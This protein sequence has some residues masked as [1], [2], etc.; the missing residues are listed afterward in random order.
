MSNVVIPPP[1]PWTLDYFQKTRQEQYAYTA[2]VIY[3]KNVDAKFK[4]VR[5]PVKSGKRS[6]PEI[7]SLINPSCEHIFVSS[8]NRKADKPQHDELKKYGI[9]VQ[10]TYNKKTAEACVALVMQFVYEGKEVHVH[11]DELDYGCKHDQILSGVYFKLKE[12]EKVSFILY[13]ATIDVVKSNYLDGEISGFHVLEPFEPAAQMYYGVDKYIEDNKLVQST[14]FV[15]FPGGNGKMVLTEQG[16]ECIQKLLEDTYNPQK[17]QHIGVLRLSGKK[18]GVHDFRLFKNHVHVVEEFAREYIRTNFGEASVVRQGIKVVF[19]NVKWDDEDY[20]SSSFDLDVPVLIVICQVAGRSTEWKCHPFLSW[21][22]TCRSRSTT[23]STLIQDQERVVFYKTDRNE[24]TDITLY[25]NKCCALYSANKINA[26]EMIMLTRKK[27]AL[28]LNGKCE[29]ASKVV[30]KAPEIFEKWEDVPEKVILKLK[31]K[32]EDFIHDG[33]KLQK[34]M[35]Y[36]KQKDN[37]NLHYTVKVPYWEEKKFGDDE[38]MYMTNIRGS[39]GNF[40]EWCYLENKG[41]KVTST[42]LRKPVWRKSDLMKTLSLGMS[43]TNPV[44]LNV[45]YEDGETNADNYKFMVREIERLEPAV[46]RNDSMYNVSE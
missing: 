36:T 46:F 4:V 6:F 12:E 45:F 8:L 14:S 16:K 25:G 37:R 13:S 41:T 26:E 1:H 17:K 20:W 38:G 21:F 40:L 35:I 15:E 34:H 24:H 18:E 39:V 9:H 43:K 10:L 29:H 28:T 30:M 7:A 3:Q 27:L 2:N 32:K 31:L 44:R 22:H 19:E 23:V 11:L 33:M 5:A 42:K